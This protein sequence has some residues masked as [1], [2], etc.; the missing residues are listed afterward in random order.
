M[1][2]LHEHG[3]GCSALHVAPLVGLLGVVASQVVVQIGLHLVD[4]FMHLSRPSQEV[5]IQRRVMDRYNV[6]CSV[7]DFTGSQVFTIEN[8]K[9]FIK[10]ADQHPAVH[11][12]FE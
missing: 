3:I 10:V 6:E 11:A 12:G 8:C 7:K 1:Q 2:A 9:P 5:F 4:V